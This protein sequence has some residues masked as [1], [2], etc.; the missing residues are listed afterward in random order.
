M[1]PRQEADELH[2]SAIGM[3][4]KLLKDFGSHIPFAIAL[5]REGNR[6][7]IAAD[8]TEIQDRDVLAAEVQE[9]V[10]AMCTSGSLK[11]V[12]FARNISFRES[13]SGP[14]ITGVEIN[15]D[16]IDD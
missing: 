12:A 15:L 14:S 2:Y 8:D 16:H 5:G 1:T 10:R 9:Q 13:P 6:I 4:M 11:A 7:N 3:A